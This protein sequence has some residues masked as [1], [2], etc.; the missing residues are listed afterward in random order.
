MN[1]L[2][3]FVPFDKWI[4]VDK[5]VIGVT[6][7]CKARNFTYG[8]WN[9]EGFDYMRTKFGTT[10]PAVEFHWDTNGAYGTVKPFKIVPKRPE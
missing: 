8:T 2:A 9:G 7:L 5:L 4:P 1:I 6:Y 10:Y 3:D